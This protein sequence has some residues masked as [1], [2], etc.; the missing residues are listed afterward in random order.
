[1]NKIVDKKELLVGLTTSSSL[2]IEM[3][4][5]STKINPEAIGIDILDYPE[6]DIVGDIYDVL[7]TAGTKWN[8]D[9]GVNFP[10]EY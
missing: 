6:V 10:E 9:G 1:M 8:F 5:G 7:K 4:C 3:G 2:I